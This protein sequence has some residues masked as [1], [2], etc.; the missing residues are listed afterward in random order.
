MY[1]FY[2]KLDKVLI[3][4]SKNAGKGKY[5][6]LL[7]EF[8][9]VYKKELERNKFLIVISSDEFPIVKIVKN[10]K[11][12][13]PNSAILVVGGDGTFNE[14]AN[15]LYGSQ[16]YLGL[17]PNGTANDLAKTLYGKNNNALNIINKSKNPKPGKIDLIRINQNKYCINITSFGYDTIVLSKAGDILHKHPSFGKSAYGLAVMKTINKVRPKEIEFELVDENGKLEKG[18]GEFI[19]T[20]ICN[21]KF[22]GDGFQP[23]PEAQVNDG[24]LN[25]NRL[26]YVPMR[27]LVPLIKTYKSGKHTELENISLNNKVTKGRFKS[28]DKTPL[29]GN[30][31]GE[32]QEFD[33][34]E[35][36]VVPKA[37]N[38]LYF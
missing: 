14:V 31:D 20:A 35:F 25:L 37:L 4:I 17:I 16:V 23:S 3:L 15:E 30:I 22:Y 2:E 38:F 21:G 9:K 19:I 34:I 5:D 11:L 12:K 24:I 18:K 26:K 8:N 27:K 13:Y 33:E 32:V 10:F 29:L 6:K 7:E 28:L 1:M 36:E